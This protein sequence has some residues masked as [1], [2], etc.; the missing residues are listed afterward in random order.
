MQTGL[1]ALAC[2]WASQ[3]SGER[4][5]R[6]KRLQWIWVWTGTGLIQGNPT[7]ETKSLEMEWNAGTWAMWGSNLGRPGL[8]R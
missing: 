4:Q 5:G 7:L 6:R 2:S 8:G 1:L 3:Q